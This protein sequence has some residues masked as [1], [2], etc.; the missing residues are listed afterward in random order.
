MVE[1]ASHRAVMASRLEAAKSPDYY[2]TPPWATRALCAELLELAPGG[3][4][5]SVWEPAC[6]AGH[7]AVPLGDYFGEVFASDLFDRGYNSHHGAQWDFLCL[8]QSSQFSPRRFDWII[9]NPPYGDLPQ[10]FVERALMHEPRKGIAVFV[11]LRWL[12]TLDR[13]RE[14]FLPHPPAM[15]G[16]FAERVPLARGKWD[17]D[18]KTATAYCWV[19]WR[20]DGSAGE[21]VLRWIPPGAAKRHSRTADLALADTAKPEPVDGGPLFSKLEGVN[22]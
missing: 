12:E 7:M 15:V 14:L 19:I 13:T 6:G 9:T 22:P 20:T 4:G 17:P 18:G 11:Q 21:P 2:P 3:A 5:L 1:P 8:D 10:R 16:V